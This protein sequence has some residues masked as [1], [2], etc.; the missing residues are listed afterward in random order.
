MRSELPVFLGAV[1]EQVAKE[2]HKAFTKQGL[3][4][5]LGVQISAVKA[6]DK[7]VTVSYADAAELAP[8]SEDLRV[9]A[10]L[11]D[12]KVKPLFPRI[13]SSESGFFFCGIKLEPLVTPSPSSS[14]PNS[15]LE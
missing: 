12:G 8:M 6:T 7:G 11:V 14:H 15:S 5:Q 10:E 4:I 9:T 2:A 1:D 13:S 3:K